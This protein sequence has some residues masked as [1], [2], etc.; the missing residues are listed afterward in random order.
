MVDGN[1]GAETQTTAA[2]G[3][4]DA[5]APS[6][7]TAPSGGKE[8]MDKAMQAAWAKR[9]REQKPEPSKDSGPGGKETHDTGA[10][11]GTGD[12]VTPANDTSPS[13]RGGKGESNPADT[14]IDEKEIAERKARNRQQAALRIARKKERQ[15]MFDDQL[16]LLQKQK[17]Q[18]EQDGEG[19]DPTMAK[20]KQDQIDQLQTQMAQELALEWRQ[21]AMEMFTP[22][23]A[24][25]FLKDSET[26][27]QWINQNEPELQQ[28]IDR[29]YGRYLLKG[30]FD[31]VAKVPANADK[32]ESMNPYQRYQMLEKNYKELEKFGEDFAAGKVQIG[33][34]Q[35]AQP[36]QQQQPPQ[37]TQPAQN[38]PSP[39]TQPRTKDVPLPGSGRNTNI[40]PPSN[41]WDL[42][43]QNAK[44]K[45]QLQ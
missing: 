11:S 7:T 33:Q 40:M 45:R 27:A 9:G 22:E 4:A 13:G 14:G 25:Q 19:N 21:E 38:Q 29:P 15:L 8:S 44:N 6:T 26:Y 12:S 35:Q 30:W 3:T 5:P 43:I 31:K 20:V 42:M 28:Y 37:Q 23:D 24:Q 36:T 2:P 41:N 1:T 18:Y 34:Q 16:N 10:K 17:A 32:W 39:E